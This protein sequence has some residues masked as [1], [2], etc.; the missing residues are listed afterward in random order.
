M[1]SRVVTFLLLFYLPCCAFSDTVSYCN[2]PD[3]N[4][5][6]SRLMLKYGDIPEWRDI[7]QYRIE[8]CKKV[9]RGSLSLEDAIDLFEEKRDEKIKHLKHRLQK[10]TT[11]TP[12]LSG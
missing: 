5:Q 8:L 3:V 7:N 1:I 10:T 9:D 11:S 4:R 12:S 2:N 6:W